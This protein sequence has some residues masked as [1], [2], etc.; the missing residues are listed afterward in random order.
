MCPCHVLLVNEVYFSGWWFWIG[1]FDLLWDFSQAWLGRGLN[2]ICC[3]ASPPVALVLPLGRRTLVGCSPSSLSCRGWPVGQS[4]YS[5]LRTAARSTVVAAN[6]QLCEGD[7][8][9]LLHATE[10]LS[11]FSCNRWLLNMETNN[12]QLK[13]EVIASGRG[14]LFYNE[15]CRDIWFF[16]P[17]I[18][19][20]DKSK[21]EKG[22]KQQDWLIVGVHKGDLVDR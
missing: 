17:C 5:Q 7:G 2:V 12:N 1:P 15:S 18:L 3:W 22:I 20:T 4:C 9:L 13:E 14:E 11:L 6:P 8:S 10:V 21:I 19:K 16:K